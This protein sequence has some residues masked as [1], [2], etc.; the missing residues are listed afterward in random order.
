MKTASLLLFLT[1]LLFDPS[2]A[3]AQS[4]W[5]D[6]DSIAEIS[7]LVFEHANAPTPNAAQEGI[8]PF[9]STVG[10]PKVSKLQLKAWIQDRK[11][12]QTRSTEAYSADASIL[13]WSMQN[14]LGFLHAG[15]LSQLDQPLTGPPLPP[16]PVTPLLNAPLLMRESAQWPEN[17]S[18][19]V[20]RIDTSEVHSL[21]RAMHWYQVLDRRT[22]GPK[23]FVTD[24]PTQT[25]TPW[26]ASIAWAEHSSN[27]PIHVNQLAGYVQLTQDQFI[28]AEVKLC[29]HETHQQTWGPLRPSY[30][31]STG[32]QV[33]CLKTNRA[34]EPDQWTYFDSETLGVL[35][36]VSTR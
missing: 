20:R 6:A 21:L 7:V 13:P 28:R 24:R 18:H 11:E 26:L 15:V 3:K 16:R 8:T 35:L 2:V 9:P 17:L 1:A 36:Q 10:L 32:Y 25:S 33:T 5:P 23:I 29:L 4:D 30:L 19:A 14:W 34:I 27:Q 12:S 31:A 22:N